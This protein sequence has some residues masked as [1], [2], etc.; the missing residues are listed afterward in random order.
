[1]EKIHSPL[2]I[3]SSHEESLVNSFFEAMLPNSPTGPTYHPPYRTFAE[4][5]KSAP[6]RNRDGRSHGKSGMI[7]TI[8]IFRKS[9]IDRLP[10][11]GM[12]SRRSHDRAS[13]PGWHGTIA[14]DGRYGC[15]PWW[16]NQGLLWPAGR[17]GGCGLC[18]TD[19]F[20]LAS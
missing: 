1:M 19:G 10:K 9:G 16:G 6:F 7:L 13:R 15:D 11:E 12:S 18:A 2:H 14:S 3:S 8:G 17:Q 5:T 4:P 20:S